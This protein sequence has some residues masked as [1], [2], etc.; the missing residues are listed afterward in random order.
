MLERRVQ[1]GWMLL[2]LN[3]RHKDISAS[4]VVF[5]S[6][7]LSFTHDCYLSSALK[8]KFTHSFIIYSMLCLWKVRQGFVVHKEFLE[9]HSKTTLQS[10]CK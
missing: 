7:L 5:I 2:D 8:D 3:T 1:D 4:F 10:K 6:L 9:L